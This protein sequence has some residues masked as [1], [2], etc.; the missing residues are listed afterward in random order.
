V[1][2]HIDLSRIVWFALY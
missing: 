2:E 1:R